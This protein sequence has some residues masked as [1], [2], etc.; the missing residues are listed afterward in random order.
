MASLSMTAS[1]R[2]RSGSCS[3]CQ[4]DRR[5]HQRDKEEICH[6]RDQVQYLQQQLTRGAQDF[7]ANVAKVA[8][9]GNP[10]YYA[11]AANKPKSMAEL[12]QKSEKFV[13]KEKSYHAKKAETPR[14]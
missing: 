6:Q 13:N 3:P 4:E 11:I 7:M 14:R 10:F 1:W 5:E 2:E 9:R 12:L 8:L